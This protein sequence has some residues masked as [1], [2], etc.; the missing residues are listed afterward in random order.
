MVR[1]SMSVILTLVVTLAI[2]VLQVAVFVTPL[3]IY[4]PSKLTVPVVLSNL[5]P[6]LRTRPLYR[7]GYHGDSLWDGA[8]VSSFSQTPGTSNRLVQRAID[9][10]TGKATERFIEWDQPFIPVMMEFGSRC[11]LIDPRPAK[12][13]ES[14]TDGN[15]NRT[16]EIVNGKPVP[17][18]VTTPPTWCRKEQRFILD[19]QPAYVWGFPDG[20]R[21]IRFDG[22]SW[23]QEF[24]VV[25]PEEKDA[26][27]HPPRKKGTYEFPVLECLSDGDRIH[28]TLSLQGKILYREGLLLR[29]ISKEG[30]EQQSDT[31][32]EF[33]T[34]TP[35]GEGGISNNPWLQ[36]GPEEQVTVDPAAHNRRFF[37]F[38]LVGG[39][40]VGI[41]VWDTHPSKIREVTVY[42]LEETGWSVFAKKTLPLGSYFFH[43][44]TQSDG[45]RSYLICSTGLGWQH[46]F[47]IEPT[48]IRR[49]GCDTTVVDFKLPNLTQHL[50][51]ILSSSVVLGTALG[52]AIWGLMWWASNPEYQ[53]ATSSVRLASIGRRGIARGL[54]LLVLMLTAG[55]IGC[56]LLYNFD[57]Y[58]FME[59]VSAK[60]THPSIDRMKLT[61]FLIFLWVVIWT[62]IQAA[63]QAWS[64]RTIGKWCCG[65][66]TTRTTFETLRFPRALLRE[67]LFYLDICYGLSFVPGI[68]F[69][70][71][72]PKRQRIGDLLAGTIVVESQSLPANGAAQADFVSDR[73]EE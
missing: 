22:K 9:P 51:A 64:G 71:L 59:A 5:L 54:D 23:G 33:G 43:A 58:D 69:I 7:G 44:V 67:I 39:R 16:W 30:D 6:Q 72:T 20:F 35:P 10:E 66:Q 50:Y 4:S 52:I 28:V 36:L 53:A 8:F 60:I 19:G 26:K 63:L 48:G 21:V 12:K 65:V 46:V 25:L 14:H 57:W 31:L 47:A 2:C 68:L 70:G 29:P 56:L 45:A 11:W 24:K 61:A 38:G 15:S 55:L 73:R 40:P 41:R 17:S 27:G 1:K 13:T 34:T 18:E 62:F 49:T 32:L 37:H 3:T 42:Q